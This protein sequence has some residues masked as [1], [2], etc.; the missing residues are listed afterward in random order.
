V[1][2]QP[3]AEPELEIVTETNE[4]NKTADRLHS[5]PD[6]ATQLASVDVHFL[7]RE[8][9]TRTPRIRARAG[10]IEQLLAELR[11]LVQADAEAAAARAEIS[12]LEQ[13]LAVAKAKLRPAKKAAKAAPERATGIYQCPD[14]PREFATNNALGAHRSRSHGFR[15]AVA[16]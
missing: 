7:L 14:C 12:Q 1:K 9:K 13:R 8:A 11:D 6:N 16:S 15:K 4:V 3:A 5:E 10:K 2:F